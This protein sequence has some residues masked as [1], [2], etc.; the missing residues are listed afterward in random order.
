LPAKIL[1]IALVDDHEVVA[2]AIKA[3]L[4]ESANLEFVGSATTVSGLFQ[5]AALADNPA[6]LVLL[7]LSLRD[8]SNPAENVEILR[9]WGAQVLAF[10]SGE[11]PYLIR[12]AARAEVLGILRKSTPPAGIV[13]AIE[14]AGA[15]N[16]VITADWAAALDSDLDLASAQLTARERQVLALYASGLGAKS[17]A[18][19]LGI[20][21]NTVDD[22]I[23]RIRREYALLGRQAGTKVDL[24]QRGIEDGYLPVPV[25]S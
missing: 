6:D 5:Y 22:H 14:L 4:A 3:L 15:G 25:S 7:D 13:A 24:Y 12:E 8:A 16:P 19:R 1:R 23:R 10:T 17:V 11:N 9:S 18:V 2:L 21:E 20:S